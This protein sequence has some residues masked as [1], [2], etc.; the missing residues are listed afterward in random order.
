MARNGFCWSLKNRTALLAA[1]LDDWKSKNT[2]AFVGASSCHA[3]TISEAVP[4]PIVVS[5][6]ELHSELQ[7]DNAGCT[8]AHKSDEV[9]KRVRSADDIQHAAIRGMF[10]RFG[11]EDDG[12][13]AHAP[14]VPLTRIG[15]ASMQVRESP[16]TGLQRATV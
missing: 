11:F 5:Q 9:A 13:N 1:R 2:G 15:H 6:N 8:W 3:E 14:T 10:E 16:A 12:S 7:L 4:N